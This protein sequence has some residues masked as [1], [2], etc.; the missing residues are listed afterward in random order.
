MSHTEVDETAEN[1]ANW[2]PLKEEDLRV[3]RF[4]GGSGDR[5]SERTDDVLKVARIGQRCE[6]GNHKSWDR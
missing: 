1:D 3:L 5:R 2:R 4:G 6:N